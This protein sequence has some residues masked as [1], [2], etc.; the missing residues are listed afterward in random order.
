M[1]DRLN[2]IDELERRL[3]ET[4]YG[5]R[6]RRPWLQERGWVPTAAAVAAAVIAAVVVALALLP[7][8][9]VTPSSARAALERAAN[10]SATGPDTALAPGKEWYVRVI[11]NSSLPEPN[12][13]SS[14]FPTTG[15]KIVGVRD[16]W[17]TID[18]STRTRSVTRSVVGGKQRSSPISTQRTGGHGLLAS[19]LIPVPLLTYRQLRALPTNPGRLR[20]ELSRILAKLKSLA[21]APTQ[22]TTT[23]GSSHTETGSSFTETAT[24][25]GRCCGSTA[26][27]RRAVTELNTIALLLALPVSPAVRAAL[28]RTAASLPGVRDDGIAHD[29]L[30]RVGVEVSVGTGE[31]QMKLLFNDHTGA[32]LESSTDFGAYAADSGFGPLVQTIG[33][34]KVVSAGR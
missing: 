5:D 22:P 20:N 14:S 26:S 12:T 11:T 13:G 17:V 18:G 16:V 33:T 9:D 4:Y 15:T 24:L 1:S 21:K 31:D 8:G 6:R 29:S 19:P 34:A 30:G 2:V 7:G 23:I 27:D 32:L 25:V 28:Y 3:V 10:A